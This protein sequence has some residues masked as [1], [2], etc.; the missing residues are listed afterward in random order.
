MKKIDLRIE[1]I[2]LSKSP[3]PLL[4]FPPLSR[5]SQDEPR[6]EFNGL[7]GGHIEYSCNAALTI[8]MGY[9]EQL[10]PHLCLI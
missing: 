3:F 5:P 7:L 4:A 1:A 10:R 6:N 8:H 2:S 9:P